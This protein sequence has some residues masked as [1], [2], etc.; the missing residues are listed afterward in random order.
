[1]RGPAYP[2]GVAMVLIARGLDPLK[3][4]KVAEAGDGTA[5]I[6]AWF[7]AEPQPTPAEVEAEL[8]AVQAALAQAA[9]EKQA[10]DDQHRA[11]ID[12]VKKAYARLQTIIDLSDIATTLQM[13]AA[14][15]EMARDI[16]HLIRAAV[17]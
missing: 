6:T 8:P 3:D 1:M 13:R 17:R 9:A 4:F 12:E 7:S 16:Q 11:S 2:V 15:K 14:I 5:R 10:A